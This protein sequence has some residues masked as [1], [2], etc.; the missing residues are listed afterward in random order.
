MIS[1]ILLAAGA[2]RRFG[3]QKL[4]EKIDGTSLVSRVASTSLN[5]RLAEL[6]VV[7]G[8]EAGVA[9]EVQEHCSGFCTRS[10]L[11][12]VTNSTPE[13][14]LMSSLKVGLGAISPDAAAAMVIHADMPLLSTRIID[15]LVLE[16]SWHGGI[17]IPEVDGEWRHPRVIPRSLF[18][19]FHALADDA[20]GTEV[21]ERFRADV[22][23]VQFDHPQ[24]F[25][26]IDQPQDLETVKHTPKPRPL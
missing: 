26:D 4:L 10:R 8:P 11:R 16:F 15:Q 3:G 23:T 19:D 9:G 22:T 13:R 5:S 18:D 17:I 6:V 25:V 21:I 1:G 20:R 24:S 7:T 12:V 14:G 2:G